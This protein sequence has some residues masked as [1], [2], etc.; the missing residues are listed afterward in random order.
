MSFNFR[1]SYRFGVDSGGGGAVLVT[2]WLCVCMWARIHFYLFENEFTVCRWNSLNLS[3]PLL[4]TLT[5]HI[6]LTLSNVN[7]Y[8]HCFCRV[9]TICSHTRQT[10]N[11][12]VSIMFTLMHMVTFGNSSKHRIYYS[13]SSCSHNKLT[14]FAPH[15]EPLIHFKPFFQVLSNFFFSTR[16][17]VPLAAFL[18]TLHHTCTNYLHFI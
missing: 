14:L 4:L 2:Q 11:A 8:W 15:H 7:M 6:V 10:A 17:T 9:C 16:D 5:V 1:T 12:I 18:I 3:L 13:L